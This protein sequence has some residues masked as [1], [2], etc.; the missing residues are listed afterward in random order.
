MS[1]IEIKNISFSYGSKKILD[2]LDWKV[3]IGEIA[4]LVGPNGCGKSTLLRLMAGVLSAENG[5]INI[6]E[7]DINS[8]SKNELAKKIAFM[9]QQ[10]EMPKDM[11]V[12]EL[13]SCGRF[14]YK[15]WWQGNHVNDDKIIMNI[16]EAVGLENFKNHEVGELSG[17]ECQRVSIA[18]ALAQE[19]KILLLD[20]PT[21]YLD[22]NYQ[23]EI[24]NI[25]KDLNEKTNLT[26][27]MVLHD[28]NHAAAYADKVAL[29]HNENILKQGKPRDVFTKETLADVFSVNADISISK[30]IPYIKIKSLR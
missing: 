20:E 25:V 17:G 14:P 2:D 28:L 3:D 9:P 22:I 24:L 5:E 26:V 19:P 12:Y 11:T 18:M 21:T 1:V 27:I 6:F 30:D 13:V 4:V 29:L 10:Q 8:Y 16:L 7:R 23:L 15:R